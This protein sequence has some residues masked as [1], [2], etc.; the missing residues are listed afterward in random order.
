MARTTWLLCIA[1]VGWVA[2]SDQTGAD[3]WVA[4]GEHSAFPSPLTVNDATAIKLDATNLYWVTRD[5]FLYR[6]PR[7]GGEV[8]RVRLPAPAE[9]LSVHNDVFVGWTDGSGSAVIEDIDPPSGRVNAT[10]HQ[11]GAL[12]ALESGQRGYSYAVA[13]PGGIRVQACRDGVCTDLI[14]IPSELMGLANDFPTRTFYVLT[15]DGLRTCTLDAG[16]PAQAT[17][18]PAATAFVDALPGTYFF[19][20][21]NGQ[22]LGKD[23]SPLGTAAVPGPTDWEVVDGA[24]DVATWSNET[25]LAQCALAPGATTSLLAVACASFDTDATGRPIFCLQ[26]SSTVQLVP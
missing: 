16:C 17:P 22:P 19:L 3:G 1:L 7:S 5:G 2:C 4:T 8:D 13:A 24:G 25:Q 26:D 10:I 14:D 6:T 21:S 20:D 11:P 18:T 12:L 15:A 23:G 9:F